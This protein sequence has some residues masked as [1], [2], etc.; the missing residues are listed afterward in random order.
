MSKNKEDEHISNLH[1]LYWAKA[2]EDYMQR[3]IAYAL[4]LANGRRYDA[5]DL[6][7]ETVCRALIY[8]RNPEGIRNPLGYL[9]RI[10]RNTWITKRH[11]ENT[12]NT[13]SLEELQSNRALKNHPTAE[14]DVFRVLENEEFEFK[15]RNLP[16]SLTTREK[17]LLTLYLRGYTV[18]EIADILNEDVRVM[19]SDLKKVKSKVR[20][21]LRGISRPTEIEGIYRDGKIALLEMPDDISEDTHV[22]VTFLDRSY[23]LQE[24]GIDE[25]RAADL[26]ARLGTFIEDWESPDMAIYDNYDALKSKL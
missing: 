17:E 3:L 12:A 6:V 19:R 2:C 18:K 21:R 23:D 10:M 4:R 11:T 14:P 1:A 7:M 22:I 16:G 20:S 5:D 24:R 13:E 8:S 15:L 25:A 9:L 26:R